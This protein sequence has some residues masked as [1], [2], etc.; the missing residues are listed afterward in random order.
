MSQEFS[1]SSASSVTEWLHGLK[2]GSVEA[3]G[4][5][6]LRYVEQLV[7]VAEQRL[8]NLPRR[9]L[10]GDDIAQE[11][12]TG[13]F[14]GVRENSFLKLDDRCDLWQ[15]LITLADRRATDALRRE[16]AERRGEGQVRGDSVVSQDGDCSAVSE[17]GF[18]NIAGPPVTP[19]S[20]DA[21]ILVIQRS[22]PELSDTELQEIALDR[23]SGY[24]TEEIA[25]RRGVAL[26]TV[27]RK[28]A[29]IRQVLEQAMLDN[30]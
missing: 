7:R 25:G 23:V 21:L 29:I 24:S 26:R 16:L 14:R 6:W 2:A 18:D 30:D 28:L 19:D 1:Q 3:S 8:K 12:F 20:A 17:A 9:S 13:F 10:D 11:A 22:F 4:K 15:L 27:E 5:I